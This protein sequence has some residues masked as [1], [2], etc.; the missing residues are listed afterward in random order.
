MKISDRV[1]N[2]VIREYCGLKDDVRIRIKKGMLRWFGH[3]ERMHDRRLTKGIYWWKC[4]NGSA[5]ANIYRLNRD[6]LRVILE[7]L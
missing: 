7:L 5:S 3:L 4:R 2:V 6:V 1:K